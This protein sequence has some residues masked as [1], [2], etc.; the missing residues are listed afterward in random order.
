[1]YE[2]ILAHIEDVVRDESLPVTK[3]EMDDA[4]MKVATLLGDIL[5]RWE[6][7]NHA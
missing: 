3:A 6:A 4:A 7:R 2:E 1:M 5:D